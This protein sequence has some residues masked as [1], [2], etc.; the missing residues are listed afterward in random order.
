MLT[1]N[2]GPLM[3]TQAAYCFAA[4]QLL[5]PQSS[6]V[7]AQHGTGTQWKTCANS[8]Y[9]YLYVPSAGKRTFDKAIAY[10]SKFP[11][12]QLAT[13]HNSVENGCVFASKPLQT[14]WLGIRNISGTW[15]YIDTKGEIDYH[16]WSPG[17]PDSSR[18]Q[19]GT[20]W[21]DPWYNASGE[22]WDNWN[23]HAMTLAHFVC[24]RKEG[25]VMERTSGGTS[26]FQP[27]T[28]ALR[29]TNDPKVARQGGLNTPAIA[30]IVAGSLLLFGLLSLLLV[31]LVWRGKHRRRQSRAVV[32][33]E[34]NDSSHS[35]SP[36]Q[37]S[38]PRISP[39][40]LTVHSGQYT[41]GAGSP[42]GHITVNVPP[43]TGSAGGKVCIEFSSSSSS[44]NNNKIDRDHVNTPSTAKHSPFQDTNS[45][46]ACYTLRHVRDMRNEEREGW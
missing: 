31:R 24:Q 41:D 27:T 15:V 17:Q 1:K 32:R 20:M 43:D 10:C 45:N 8:S 7:A 9:E 35:N 42:W 4:Y 40:D 36:E 12:G 23:C 18:S 16:N 5:V 46:P 3:L 44:C 2:M 33:Q 39:T 11:G 6:T 26:R 37:V 22:Q 25:M 19:C 30:G 29:E 21:F 13:P 14:I 38:V 28:P 34:Q